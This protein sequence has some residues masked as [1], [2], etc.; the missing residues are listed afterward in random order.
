MYT[1]RISS[2]DDDRTTAEKQ[3]VTLFRSNSSNEIYRM[4][5]NVIFLD[6]IGTLHTHAECS[7]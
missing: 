4:Q 6:A 1:W 2:V 5:L 7:Y 3:K